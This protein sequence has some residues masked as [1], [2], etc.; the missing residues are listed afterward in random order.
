M[1]QRAALFL[2]D[3]TRFD[4]FGLEHRGLAL[5]AYTLA[6]PDLPVRRFVE[7]LSTN[8][9]RILGVQGGALS[10]GAPADVTIF[11][12]RAWAVDPAA[13]YSKGKCTP[14]AG[15]TFPRRAVA[16]IVD[17]RLVMSGGRVLTEAA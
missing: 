14:F 2:A 3:G 6:V 4:G 7:L 12:D 9:A 10:L 13:F 15:M 11:A 8:P 16:T 17:G 1:S 5:G